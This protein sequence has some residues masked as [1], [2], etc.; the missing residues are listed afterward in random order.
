MWNLC[1]IKCEFKC[2][3]NVNST[4]CETNVKSEWNQS[5]FKRVDDDARQGDSGKFPRL[6]LN[7]CYVKP[8]RNCN[9]WVATRNQSEI[10][11]VQF[12]C[13][14]A[15]MLATETQ[16]NFPGC[17]CC[18]SC[19]LLTVFNVDC[20][21]TC[22]VLLFHLCVEF[23]SLYLALEFTNTL[24]FICKIYFFAYLVLLAI[25]ILVFEW[26]ICTLK[27]PLASSLYQTH[28]SFSLFQ[29][30]GQA[31]RIFLDANL[32]SKRRK[33]SKS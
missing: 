2:E 22:S 20:L 19:W 28:R 9:I 16:A 24:A 29:T 1:E 4:A 32:A 33:F 26:I 11:R 12:E 21:N 13:N 10:K 27:R 31:Y 3:F 15:M 8:K 25:T 14:C 30:F 23:E 18:I 17:I 7:A 5:E 6:Y